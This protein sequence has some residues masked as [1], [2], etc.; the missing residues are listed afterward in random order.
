MIGKGDRDRMLQAVSN[1]QT[2]IPDA[3]FDDKLD[4]IYGR[5]GAELYDWYEEEIRAELRR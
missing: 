5:I 2:E 3:H 4:C 1:A